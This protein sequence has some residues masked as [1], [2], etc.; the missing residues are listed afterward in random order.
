MSFAEIQFPADISY[1]SLGGPEYSTDILITHSGHEQRN[2]NWSQARA[3]YNV[4]YGVKT[5]EQL[6]ALIAF[7]RTRK[8]QAEGFRFKDWTDFEGIGEAIGTGDGTR[9]QFQLTKRYISGSESNN[10][11]ITKPVATT[12]RIYLDGAL[13]SSG[14]TVDEAT[15]IVTFSSAPGSGVVILADFEFDVPV[16]FATDRLSRRLDDYGVYSAQDIALV[17]VRNDVGYYG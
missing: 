10:R 17:E 2:S 1:G 6:E 12:V 7:F 8:G 13:Q 4:A 9:T 15:G 5:K 16:R 14:F 3:R 11:V